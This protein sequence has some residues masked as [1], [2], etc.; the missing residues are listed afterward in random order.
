MDWSM[1]WPLLMMFLAF[2]LFFGTVLLI[3]LRAELLR[4]ERG[5]SWVREVLS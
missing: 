4:R 3:R 2:M 5:A 1:V